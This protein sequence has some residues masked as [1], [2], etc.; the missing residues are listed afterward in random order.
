MAV[1][2]TD[3]HLAVT[4]AAE[5]VSSAEENVV[6]TTVASACTFCPHLGRRGAETL[7]VRGETAVNVAVHRFIL[8]D[9]VNADHDRLPFWV[10]HAEDVN[11][12]ERVR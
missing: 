2:N 5:R 1:G 6:D 9:T 4:G 11:L 8:E 10:R 7:A 12:N 3:T